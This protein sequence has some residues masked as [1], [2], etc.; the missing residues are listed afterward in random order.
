METWQKMGKK[1]P[2]KQW[3]YRIVAEMEAPERIHRFPYPKQSFNKSKR[4][5]FLQIKACLIPKR[6]IEM[7]MVQN[8][9]NAVI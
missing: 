8:P 5:K 3:V 7:D 4:Q 1:R 2:G 6:K 9:N